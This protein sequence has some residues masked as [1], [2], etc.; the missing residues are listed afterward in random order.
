MPK[1]RHTPDGDY[2]PG[3]GLHWL[4]PLYD[5]LSRLLGAGRLHR[6]LLDHADVRPGQRVLEIGC[7]TG[8]LL[9]ELA[10]RTPGIDAVGIDPDPGALRR[11]RRKAAKAGLA[12]GYQRAFAGDLPFA[13]ADIDVVLSSLMLHH[14]DDPGRARALGEV[15]RVLRPGGRLHVLDIE[16]HGRSGGL[17]PQ[18]LTTAGLTAATETGRGHFRRT[19]G[20][21][22]LRAEKNTTPG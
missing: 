14:L 13:D 10:R 16:G 17:T 6:D 9:T 11:A 15:R 3:I 1:L 12:I 5:P 20:Y 22:I 18:T 7:G 4:M 19:S 21:V 2:L 8:N